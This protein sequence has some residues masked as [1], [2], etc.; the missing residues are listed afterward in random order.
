MCHVIS[1]NFNNIHA[2]CGRSL[3]Q[4]AIITV[5]LVETLSAVCLYLWSV[6]QAC[7]NSQGWLKEG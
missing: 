4:T 7:A 6:I 2:S 1:R 5:I 3:E